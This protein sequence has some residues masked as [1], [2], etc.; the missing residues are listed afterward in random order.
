MAKRAAPEVNAGSMADIAFLL[1]IF[2]LVTT[3]IETD[4]GIS[5]KLPPEQEE[6]Q[7]PPPVIK[8]RNL[9]TV[10]VNSND[11]LLVE[12]EVMQL[13]DLR[14]AA[15]AFLDNGAEDCSYCQGA[16]S[17]TSSVNPQKAIISLVNNRGTTYK[18]YI[19]VQNELVAAYNEL[20]DREA[21]SKYGESFVSMEKRYNDPR[22][23]ERDKERLKPR[24]E[25][26]RELYPEKLSEAE[27]KK[28]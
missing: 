16:K 6:N 8:E 2:F 10:I 25:E 14:A 3:T 27:P 23:S 5:R 1:L 11:E 17:E 7:P 9:F 22:T 18:R 4:S 15:V 20:R 12:D 19:A 28:N 21:Q 13:K 24:V 26:I